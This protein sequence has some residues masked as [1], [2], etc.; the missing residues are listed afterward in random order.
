MKFEKFIATFVMMNIVLMIGIVF[1]IKDGLVME[2]L[3][4]L[5][6][7]E[8]R[9]P[10]YYTLSPAELARDGFK[11]DPQELIQNEM[12]N[13]FEH[14]D[15]AEEKFEAIR[16]LPPYERAVEIVRLYSLMGDGECLS[17]LTIA[18]KIKKAEVKSGCSKD[19]AE[20]FILLGTYA[21]LET[22]MVS[23]G[24]HYGAEFFNGHKWIYIDPY[25]AMSIS[26]KTQRLSFAEFSQRMLSDGWIRFDF[27]GGDN[28]C[29]SGKQISDHPYF[30]DKNQYAEIYTLNGNNVIEMVAIENSLKDKPAFKRFLYPYNKVKGKLIITELQESQKSI[31]RKYVSGLMAILAVMF[32][33]T[34]ILLPIYYFAGLFGRLRKKS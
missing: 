13:I 21:G 10:D 24:T 3:S 17:G 33:S 28:H 12:D 23:N 32:I 1:S 16:P 4:E 9:S 5:I 7:G 34:N 29:M 20:I 18:E 26:G 22:R 25:F 2:A 15:L 30:G 14:T 31:I 27:F 8:K 11:T 19:F 6:Y